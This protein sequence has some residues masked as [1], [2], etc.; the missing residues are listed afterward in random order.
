MAGAAFFKDSAFDDEAA[1]RLPGDVMLMTDL[2]RGAVL[3]GG[4]ASLGISLNK[5]CQISR[6]SFPH[7]DATAIDRR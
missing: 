4:D 1:Y 6:M 3:T 2:R 5:M 7:A